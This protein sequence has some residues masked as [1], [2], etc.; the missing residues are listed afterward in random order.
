MAGRAPRGVPA[1]RTARV[2]AVLAARAALATAP[3]VAQSARTDSIALLGGRIAAHR[4]L[5]AAAPRCPAVLLLSGDGGWALGVVD[6]ARRLQGEGFEVVGIDAAHLVRLAGRGG[7]AAIVDAWPLLRGLTSEP[8]VLLGYSRGAT[9][10]LAYATRAEPPPDAVLAGT[11]L[12]D[13]FGGPAAPRGLAQ[14]VL[15]HGA[16][17]VDLRPLYRDGRRATRV[18][19]IHGAR[20]QVAPYA[21]VRAW[22]DS[23]PEPKRIT[24]LPRSGHGFADERALLPALRGALDWAAGRACRAG[25]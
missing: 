14:G 12:E 9:L 15:R 16:Y 17:V 3:L 18:A 1:V 10:G 25:R 6:W 24:I 2:L 20:D 23:L 19:I 8:P 5:P 13:A 22:F 4:Y 11:D 21:M 7:L